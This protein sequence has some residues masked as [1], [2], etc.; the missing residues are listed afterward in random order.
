VDE[1]EAGGLAERRPD[2]S[3]RRLRMIHLTDRGTRTLAELRRISAE[4]DSELTAGL[5]PDEHDV[6]VGLLERV[7][8][9][10]GLT[11]GIH[12]GIRE[13]PPRRD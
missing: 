6:L 8:D 2:A 5:S 1:L 4:H 12:P 11:R 13:A 10:A 7:A 3:D 9:D